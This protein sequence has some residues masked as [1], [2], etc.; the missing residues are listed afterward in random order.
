LG[1]ISATNPLNEENI[2]LFQEGSSSAQVEATSSKRALI[3]VPTLIFGE[4]LKL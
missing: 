4:E 3:P 2:N 1:L